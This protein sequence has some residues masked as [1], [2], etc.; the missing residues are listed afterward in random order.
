MFNN[1]SASMQGVSI[2]AS[3]MQSGSLEAR[4]WANRYHPFLDILGSNDMSLKSFEQCSMDTAENM[5]VKLSSKRGHG[6]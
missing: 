4:T 3:R 5:K 1:V 6:G 2:A